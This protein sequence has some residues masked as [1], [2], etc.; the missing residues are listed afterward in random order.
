[1]QPGL[2][3]PTRRCPPLTMP[4][5][6]HRQP[7]KEPHLRRRGRPLR[8]R[9]APPHRRARRPIDGAVTH[10]WYATTGG[11]S[12]RDD[13]D[14]QQRAGRRRVREDVGRREKLEEDKKNYNYG[15]HKN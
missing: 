9:V 4:P 2:L 11:V 3:I 14:A 1:M 7:Q 13:D 10:R 15:I 8:R 6:G 5:P 12:G